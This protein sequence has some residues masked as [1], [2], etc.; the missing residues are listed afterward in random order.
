MDSNEP[1]SPQQ[2]HFQDSYWGNDQ[3]Y[4]QEYTYSHDS[5]GQLAYIYDVNN[6]NDHVQ[7]HYPQKDYDEYSAYHYESKLSDPILYCP[8]TL[9]LTLP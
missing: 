2:F 5:N 6:D 3:G 4:D 7:Y 9:D 1:L 8:G